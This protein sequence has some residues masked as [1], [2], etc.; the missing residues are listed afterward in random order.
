M[1]ARKTPLTLDE[2][3]QLGPALARMRDELV[4]IEVWLSGEHLPTNH[5]VVRR[6]VAAIINIDQARSELEN[7]MFGQHAGQ[8]GVS[9][10]VYYP[11][12]AD[13]KAVA[14]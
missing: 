5:L 4:S 12:P 1:T 6:L 11:D 9:P 14:S 7:V 13:R 3:Q 8:P 10:D 2:H